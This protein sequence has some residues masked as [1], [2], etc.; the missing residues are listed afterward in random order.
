M[1]EKTSLVTTDLF[2][3][4]WS[5]TLARSIMGPVQALW[6]LVVRGICVVIHKIFLP[7]RVDAAPTQGVRRLIFQ[8]PSLFFLAG[9]WGRAHRGVP[10]P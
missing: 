4:W 5:N 3:S 10:Y 9:R 2:L 8:A 6:W 1:E 7:P